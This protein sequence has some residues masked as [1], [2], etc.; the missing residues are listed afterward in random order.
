MQ[1]ACPIPIEEYPLV[2]LAHGGLP[3]SLAEREVQQ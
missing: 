1:L 3:D 2:T